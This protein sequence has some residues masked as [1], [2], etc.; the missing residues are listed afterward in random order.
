MTRGFGFEAQ[1]DIEADYF[2]D[3]K[4]IK[5]VNYTMDTKNMKGF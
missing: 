2:L 3:E 1:G 4:C 5:Q